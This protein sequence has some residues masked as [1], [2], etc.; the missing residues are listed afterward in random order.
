MGVQ[1]KT[2]KSFL[3]LSA[4]LIL[5]I[6]VISTFNKTSKPKVN[7]KAETEKPSIY[8]SIIE[9]PANLRINPDNM[10]ITLT[11]IPVG[12]KLQV[13]DKCKWVS[14][15]KLRGKRVKV[16]WYKV[17]YQNKTGWISEHTC[18]VEE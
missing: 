16:I 12:T 2:F 17:K 10:K 3:L 9:H 8:V 5:T 11:K 7:F 13:L 1:V 15:G 4:L 14:P 6:I 18:K